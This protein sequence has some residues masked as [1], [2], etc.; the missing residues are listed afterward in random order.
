MRECKARSNSI[1][2]ELKG[3]D[4]GEYRNMERIAPVSYT[5]LLAKVF[6][7]SLILDIMEKIEYAPGKERW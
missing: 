2:E 4:K 3:P 7:H 5:H 1:S 6:P